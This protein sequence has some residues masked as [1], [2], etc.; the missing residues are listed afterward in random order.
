MID[1]EISVGNYSREGR[2]RLTI[3][4]HF[5]N[6]SAENISPIRASRAGNILEKNEALIGN[7]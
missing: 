3:P 4:K 6:L 5:K 2:S 7:R 1:G